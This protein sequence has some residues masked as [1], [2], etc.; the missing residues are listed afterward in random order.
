VLRKEP[1]AL[2]E[3]VRESIFHKPEG[4]HFD[5]GFS[6]RRSMDNIGG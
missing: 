4:H 5:K 2:E 3:L 1:E 6:S